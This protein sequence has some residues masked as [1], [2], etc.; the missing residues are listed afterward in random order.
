MIHK[1][2]PQKYSSISSIYDTRNIM[3]LITE[4]VCVHP[5]L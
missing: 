2:F 4:I 1:L 3:Y 5:N